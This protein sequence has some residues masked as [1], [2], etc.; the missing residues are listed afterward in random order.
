MI[1]DNITQIM[2]NTP[3]IN[4]SNTL[5]YLGVKGS[6]YIKLEYLLPGLSKKDRVALNIIKKA[7]ERGVLMPNQPVVETT[8]GNT[9]IGLAIVCRHTNHPFTAVMSAGNSA[10]RV[11]MI[12]AL[13]A[14]I[15]L[16]PQAK[17]S[18]KGK[19]SGEDLKL[20]EAEAMRICKETGA[21]MAS[22]FDNLDNPLIHQT[23][24]AEEIYSQTE[25]EIDAFAD[26]IGTGGS[27][28]GICMG[29]KKK[30]KNIL[31]YGVEPEVASFY[32]DKTY[33]GTHAIQGGGYFR[34]VAFFENI[35]HLINGFIKVT[36][37]EAIKLCRILSSED[38]I[39]AGYS[40]GANAAAAVKLLEGPLENKKIIILANDTGLKYMSTDL[41]NE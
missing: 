24:T 11:K 25:G 19:V 16:V 31:C 22:Q 5:K 28:A 2:K 41:W 1:Y 3:I 13:G 14:N 18:V 8:S 17:N 12:K 27:L 32:A 23:A 21:F 26:F 35:K 7:N 38:S 15:V 4:A 29:L 39:F 10:E 36:D 9:G 33:K 34:E 37:K 6:L 40:T 20:V 30:N